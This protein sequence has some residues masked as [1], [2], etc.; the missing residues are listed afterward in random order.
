MNTAQKRSAFSS[1]KA[2]LPKR[3]G[4]VFECDP[5]LWVE[6]RPNRPTAPI[7]LGLRIVSESDVARARSVAESFANQM[8]RE[9]PYG[10]A[11][12]E[13]FNSHLI[14]AIMFD[15]VVHPDNAE[16]RWFARESQVAL[17]LTT[18]GLKFL[19]DHYEVYQVST[20]KIAPEA[21]DDE[22]LELGDVILAGALFE[23]LDLERAR[24]V[25][26]LLKAALLEAA[27]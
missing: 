13:C 6:G 9:L 12:I 7:Q 26:R 11:W 24:R 14:A 15:A 1:I 17:D 22:L 20:S 10:E 19:W 27:P 16:K 18:N 3:A 8:H 23:G 21:S 4:H 25:R 5:S 2:A